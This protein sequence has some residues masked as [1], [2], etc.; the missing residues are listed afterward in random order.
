MSD[1]LKIYKDVLAG[2]K[3]ETGD[4]VPDSFDEFVL[5]NMCEYF[6]DR[7][8]DNSHQE[9]QRLREL[10]REACLCLKAR[11][12]HPSRLLPAEVWELGCEHFLNK[13]EVKEILSE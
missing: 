11:N 10:L 1:F 7:G 9:N 13:D 3:E 4:D 8:S 6:Y 2:Y 12:D 5:R